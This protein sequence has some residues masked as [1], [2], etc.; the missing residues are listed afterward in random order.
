[1]LLARHISLRVSPRAVEKRMTRMVWRQEIAMMDKDLCHLHYQQ[2]VVHL[3]HPP[4]GT[5]SHCEEFPSI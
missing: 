2:Q 3:L 1:M 5:L 4:E